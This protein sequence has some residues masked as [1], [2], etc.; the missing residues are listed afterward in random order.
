MD[1]IDTLISGCYDSAMSKPDLEQLEV[2]VSTLLEAYRKLKD[3][4][5]KL[6]VQVEKLTREG[7]SSSK[8]KEFIKEKLGR[9]SELEEA[10]KNN[11]NDRKQIREK[12]AHLLEKLETFDL[13]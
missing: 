3:E 12:I 5:Q 1:T 7:Q 4:N 9:L 6:T 2:S 13:T 10:N 11:E 8:E